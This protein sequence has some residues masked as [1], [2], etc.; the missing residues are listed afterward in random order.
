M[1]CRDFSVDRRTFL[2][3]AA[4][5]SALA[6]AAGCSKPSDAAAKPA[7]SSEVLIE[8]F[9]ASGKSLG[10]IPVPKVVKTDAEWKAQLSPLAYLVTRHEDTERAFTGEYA[11]SKGDGLYRCIC[12]GTALYDSKTKYDSGT[13][14]PSFWQPISEH[15]ID[16]ADD[17][18]LI[19][20]RTAIS[21]A[22]CDAHLG[23]VFDDGPQPTG[24]RYCM[25]SVSL[26]F[27]PR[28]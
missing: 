16:R 13:G 8:N 24:L 27:V 21:C 14:W 15:N 7:P 12:C 10:T 23:H 6:I 26:R 19:D 22:L 17:Y 25:N 9:D 11:E 18:K 4:S 20:K 3:S 1:N 5:G 28:G 2:L